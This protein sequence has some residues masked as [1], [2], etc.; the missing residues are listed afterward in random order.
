[1]RWREAPPL[2]E[3][4]RRGGAKQTPTSAKCGEAKQTPPRCILLCKALQKGPP[5]PG[6]L[7]SGLLTAKQTALRMNGRT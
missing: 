2:R 3:A 4:N 7:Q 1:L 6:S 5:D